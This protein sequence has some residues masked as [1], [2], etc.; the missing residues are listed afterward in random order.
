M[1]TLRLSGTDDMIPW[2]DL[3]TYQ[4]QPEADIYSKH[5]SLEGLRNTQ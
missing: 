3:G 2:Q 5:D 4:E 1:S